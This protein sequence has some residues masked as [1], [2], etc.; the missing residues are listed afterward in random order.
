MFFLMPITTFILALIISILSIIFSNFLLK[1]ELVQYLA[2][3]YIFIPIIYLFILFIWISVYMIFKKTII[4]KNIY[5]LI[6]GFFTIS[7][8]Y[9]ILSPFVLY[10]IIIRIESVLV[11]LF[12]AVIPPILFKA[13]FV[14]KKRFK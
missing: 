4:S 3:I 2:R 9:F 10:G 12:S 6:W 11:V 13:F 5:Y 8:L 14:P 1:Y 7:G